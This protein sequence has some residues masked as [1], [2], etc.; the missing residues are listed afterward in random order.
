MKLK[1]LIVKLVDERI[2]AY[3]S[4]MTGEP[5][6]RRRRSYKVKTGKRPGRPP[7]SKN[8]PKTETESK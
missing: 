3:F 4:E 8:K 6:V 2:E 5:T 1:E 7:G